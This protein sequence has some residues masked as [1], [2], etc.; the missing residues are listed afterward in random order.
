MISIGGICNGNVS[1]VVS[2][3]PTCQ[4]PICFKGVLLSNNYRLGK[5]RER[6][7]C[8]SLN[9]LLRFDGPEKVETQETVRLKQNPV[10][11]CNSQS[12]ISNLSDWY[13]SQ[14]CSF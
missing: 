7:M 2:I 12:Q 9:C 3:V 4:P 13:I 6:S 5:Q 10:E 11:I 1:G 14:V 8:G